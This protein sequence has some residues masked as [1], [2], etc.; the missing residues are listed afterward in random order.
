MENH[1][2][3]ISFELVV[4]NVSFSWAHTPVHRFP[5]CVSVF[6][7]GHK[8]WNVICV[9]VSFSPR[10]WVNDYC[11]SW[12]VVS[13][14]TNSGGRNGRHGKSWMKAVISLALIISRG[15]ARNDCDWLPRIEMF[16]SEIIQSCRFTCRIHLFHLIIVH[17]HSLPHFA[18]FD[19]TDKRDF[20]N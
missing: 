6:N 4:E 14:T 19:S 8:S 15:K 16:A 5:L 17:A 9:S 20:L 3:D 7:P 18:P 13:G 11:L 10:W 1:V 12:I 2:M